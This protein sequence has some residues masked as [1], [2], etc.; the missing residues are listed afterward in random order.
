MNKTTSEAKRLNPLLQWQ[1]NDSGYIVEYKGLLGE[2]LL[3]RI[4]LGSISKEWRIEKYLPGNFDPYE[5][6]DYT[7][8]NLEDAKQRCAEALENWTAQ[9]GVHFQVTGEQQ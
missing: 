1:E 8:P 6:E 2:L 9:S 5:F 7:T 3:F 4:F